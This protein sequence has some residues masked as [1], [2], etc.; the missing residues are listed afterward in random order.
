VSV[1]AAAGGVL[2]AESRSCCTAGRRG[3]AHGRLLE[4]LSSVRRALINGAVRG[5]SGAT[6]TTVLR[7]GPFTIS[8]GRITAIDALVDPERLARLDR[9]LRGE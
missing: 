1:D 9:D 6:R 8:G 2:R 7:D 4:P 3:R 5:R